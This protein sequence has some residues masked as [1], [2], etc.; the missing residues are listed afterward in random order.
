MPAP[1]SPQWFEA[2]ALDRPDGSRIAYHRSAGAAGKTGLVWLG[3]FR[4]D[5]EG[6]KAVRLHDWARE[7]ERPFVRFD[8]FGHGASSG[9]FEDG[10]IGRWMDD[11]LAVIDAL[12]DG[13]QVLVGSSMGGWIALLAALA[14]PE[15]VAGLILIAPAPD[16]TERLMW[17]SF[18]ADVRSAILSKG[19]WRMPS[20]YG[21]EPTPITRTLIEDGR[22]H[23][24]LDKPSI[25]IHVPVCIIQGADDPDVP[26]RHALQLVSRLESPD[27]S[28]LRIPGGD[29]RLSTEADLDRLVRVA[30]R[31]C[32]QLEAPS[33]AAST[34][35]SPSR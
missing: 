3:G 19:V 31:F 9:A 35:A 30:G 11:A 33:S 23:L 8:Y 6:S 17:A 22:K 10:S 1:T 27:V 28:F 14:R 2:H 15:R 32:D 12:T 25:P 26:W 29:H 20:D 21:E 13:P 4:S 34:A 7:A 5:M 18:S 16:F 24:L